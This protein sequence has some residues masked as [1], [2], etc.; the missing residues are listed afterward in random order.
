MVLLCEALAGVG[1]RV[2]RLFGDGCA[3]GPQLAGAGG[4][5]TKMKRPDH[6]WFLR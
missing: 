2:E 3:D 4:V 5:V 6:F 1:Q